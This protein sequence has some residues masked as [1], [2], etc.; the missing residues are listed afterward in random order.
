MATHVIS[1][2]TTE[3]VSDIYQESMTIDYD[4]FIMFTSQV[5]INSD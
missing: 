2:V 3:H 4:T 1:Q 5:T